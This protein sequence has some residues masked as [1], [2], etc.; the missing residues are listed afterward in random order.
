MQDEIEKK[1]SCIFYWY[2]GLIVY[3]Q[4]ANTFF[5]VFH[6]LDVEDSEETLRYKMGTVLYM[7]NFF[8]QSII[9]VATFGWA[10]YLYI[11]LFQFLRP[12]SDET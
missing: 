3:T 9:L 4:A 2:F 11:K 7:I 10:W 5:V 1:L 6:S 8:L 12:P